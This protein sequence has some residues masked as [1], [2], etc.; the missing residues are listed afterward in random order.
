MSTGYQIAGRLSKK[1][2]TLV[3]TE[4]QFGRCVREIFGRIRPTKVIET[5]TYWGTGTTTIIARALRDLGIEDAQFVSIEVN[6]INVARARR[7]LA[8]AGLSVD[9]INALSV[10]RGL[11][12]TR[13]QIERELVKTVQADGLIVDHEE[14][15]RA[16]LYFRETD[17]A[18]LPED[19]LGDAIR[20]F[21]HRPD[22][23]LLDSGGHMG[24]VEFRYAI[25]QIHAPCHIALDDVFH[26]KHFRSFTDIKNDP[27]F[28]IVAAS[29]EKFGFC[30]AYFEPDLRTCAQ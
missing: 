6:P 30:I 20:R 8:E 21:D 18:D 23:V 17:F 3:E 14:H 26:V 7:N 11:L 15:E 19:A 10:P 9:L 1:D 2:L 12:P 16:Q 28:K 13:E 25:E 27:R 4:S 5:G 24:Y 29:E 22:F